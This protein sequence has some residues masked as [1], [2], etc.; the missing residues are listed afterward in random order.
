MVLSELDNRMLFQRLASP[1]AFSFC[2]SFRRSSSNSY[3]S[4]YRA[5]PDPDPPAP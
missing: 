5:F 2:L 4:A 1:L 3:A